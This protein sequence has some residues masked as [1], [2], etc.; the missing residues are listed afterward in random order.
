MSGA[1]RSDNASAEERADKVADEHGLPE[2][3]PFAAVVRGQRNA[4]ASWTEIH[5]MI[6]P[7]YDTIDAAALEESWEIVPEW[8][9]AVVEHDP[10]ATSGESYSY[11]KR[12]AETAEA[13][14]QM[15]ENATGLPVDSEKTEQIGTQKVA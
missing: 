15:V 9:V 3:N 6:E 13:A 1:D 4:G 7:V 11:Y 12:I 10:D 14:E 2:D 8:R 5:E